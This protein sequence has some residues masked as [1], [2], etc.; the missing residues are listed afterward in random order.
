MFS[1]PFLIAILVMLLGVIGTVLPALPGTPLI[2]LAAAGY[3]Y[4][5]GFHKITPTI[6]IILFVIMAITF[7]VDYLAGVIGAKK[8]GASRYGTWGS[9]IGGIAGVIIFNIP[10]LLVGPFLGAVAGEIINGTEIKSALRVGFGTV[11]GLAGGAMIK[12]IFAL[13]M[14]VVFLNGVF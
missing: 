2:F 13:S 4:Y 3:G 8:Y 7:I 10:G 6:L 9:F 12:L 5:E 14:I 1:W 11:V